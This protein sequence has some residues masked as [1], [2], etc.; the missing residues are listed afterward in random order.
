VAAD[1][2]YSD[3]LTIRSLYSRLSGTPSPSRAIAFPSVAGTSRFS[4]SPNSYGLLDD[5]ASTPVARYA[6][7][8]APKLDLPMLPS[9]PFSVL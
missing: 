6:V 9:S 8:W 2:R 1:D 7:S 5:S 4:T 3:W